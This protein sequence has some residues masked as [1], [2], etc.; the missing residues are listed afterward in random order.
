MVRGDYGEGM[1]NADKLASHLTGTMVLETL[2]IGGRMT[3]RPL[4]STDEIINAAHAIIARAQQQTEAL[5]KLMGP[6]PRD[7]V[8]RCVI[9]IGMTTIRADA[10]RRLA[11]A[12]DRIE[13][14]AR[15]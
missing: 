9:R 12:L 5:L 4:L 10:D 8:S 7:D 14:R 13:L 1:E 2:A 6:C 3:L 15:N 11:E